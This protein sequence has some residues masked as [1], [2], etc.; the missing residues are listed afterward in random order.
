MKFSI[1]VMP[2]AML[3]S[4]C[5]SSVETRIS[6]SGITPVEA[7]EYMLVL[8]ADNAPPDLR[9][10]YF[11]VAEKLHAK[12][13]TVSETAALHLEIT[14]DARDASLA[15]GSTAGP[16]SLSAPKRKKPLQSCKDK[17]YRLGVTLTRIA[18]GEEI[19][20]GRVAEY[21]CRMTVAEALP[22]LVDAALADFGQPRGSYAVMRT[23]KD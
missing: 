9:G 3:V 20:R 7:S 13:F 21:H 17:E 6:S 15:L 2:A 10:A 4:G 8:P 16:E 18:D 19:Y 14:L 22:A 12:G 5:G 1:F 11:R 23:A